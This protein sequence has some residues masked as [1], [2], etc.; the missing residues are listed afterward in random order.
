MI[1]LDTN[2]VIAAINQR[3]PA[4]RRRLE[5]ALIYGI[6]IGIPAIVLYELWYGIKKS[7]RPDANAALLAAFLTLD[8]TPWPFGPGDA[9]E[10]GDIRA[11][12]ERAGTPIGP[13]DLLIAGQ[14]RRRSA[15]LVTA[16]TGEFAR[17]PGLVTEDWAAG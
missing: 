6:E 12:L 16:N 2:I 17:V 14:A 9:E 15:V 7:A 8:L 1:C 11:I 4:V 5:V 3:R 13:Y 10:A